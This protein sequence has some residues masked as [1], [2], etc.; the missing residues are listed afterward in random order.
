VDAPTK[1][2]F[3][4]TEAGAGL[5]LALAAAAG[6][7]AANSALAPFYFGALDLELPLDLGV[8]AERHS[9][10]DWIKEGL[11]AVFFFAVGLEIKF[12][13][14]KG[15]LSTPRKL[16]LPV[17]AALGGMAV[18]A[19]IYLA[20]NLGP[21]GE[22]QGWPI[23]VATDIV[24]ALAALAAVGA[25]APAS[26]RAF[27]LALAVADDLGAVLLIAVLFTGGVAAPML[28]GALATLAAM[29]ALG[30]WRRAPALLYVLGAVLVWAFTLKSGV[31]TSVGAVAAA[32]TVPLAPRPGR[33]GMVHAMTEALRPWVS[34]LILPVF[35]FAASGFAL[36]ALRPADLVSP[37]ALG[38]F[39]GLVVGKPVG[40]LAASWLAVR[41]KLAHRPAG[42][43][44]SQVAGVS[45]LCGVGFTMS[46]YLAGLAFTA[47]GH[48][49]SA[50]RLGVILGSLVATAAGVGLL[51]FGRSASPR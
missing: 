26:L 17:L 29:M 4:K 38:V 11:M 19:L 3:L 30:Y 46:L 13:V 21:G 2:H 7:L 22:P 44:W 12:E 36:A 42:A 41:L 43:A 24:F 45:L 6:L 15:E 33:P 14:L 23:P 32:L 50:A 10:L 31:S 18:P 34:F 9:L 8:W 48:A 39:A 5:I 35:A 28:A 1:S 47:G 25:R 37:V 40:V 16:A 27:L 51:R 20:L 49:S